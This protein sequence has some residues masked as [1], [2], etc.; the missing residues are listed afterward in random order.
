[1]DRRD[2][3][4][5]AGL[6]AIGSLWPSSPTSTGDVVADRPNIL[7]VLSDDQPYYTATDMMPDDS[8]YWMP[9]LNEAMRP[10]LIF[11][12]AYV[13]SPLCG[14]SRASMLTGL[15]PHNTGTATVPPITV[16]EHAC[17][18]FKRS[19]YGTDEIGYYLSTYAGYDCG[20]FGKPTNMYEEVGTWV[21]PAYDKNKNPN[22]RW[23]GL[24]VDRHPVT[25][26]ANGRVKRTN[27]MAK[28]ETSYLTTRAIEFI[29][30]DHAGNP[31]FCFASVSSPHSPYLPSDAHANDFAG[32]SMPERPSWNHFDPNKPPDVR[33]EYPLS[34]EMQSNL[35]S[36][37]K[38][39]MRE[40]QDLDDSF[41]RLMEV[42]SFDDTYVFFATD[43]GYLLGEHCLHQKAQ[44][45]EEAVRTPLFIRGPGMRETAE[46]SLLATATDIPATILDLAGLDP[47]A[48]EYSMDGRS[49]VPVMFTDDESTLEWRD[50]LLIEQ[51]EANSS[52]TSWKAVTT[53]DSLYASHSDG[54]QE[55]YD[56]AN[57][58]YQLSN[59][60]PLA[61]PVTLYE[62]DAK[63]GELKTACGDSLR[64]AEVTT[65]V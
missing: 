29:Q 57:D 48:P 62:M 46:T 58:P 2:F 33:R 55:F 13:P 50:A 52:D 49:L 31:W 59:L 41:L 47:E 60:A 1:M 65:T 28:D 44:P 32:I 23:Y 24:F 39:K 54:T 20:F 61:D 38:G 30:Q 6:S 25:V 45:Y 7:I 10:G 16:N 21:P 56:L 53:A 43:N 11:N 5:L 12:R 4:S 8:R 34:S 64:A 40:L 15:Y 27:V 63:L 36:A 26:N 18:R 51:A 42:I 3:L 17:R 14:P 35:R 9:E 37:W 19:G 22:N